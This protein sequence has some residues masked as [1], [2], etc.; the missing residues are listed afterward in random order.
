MKGTKHAATYERGTFFGSIRGNIISFVMWCSVL[1]IAVPA[2]M[3]SVVMRNTLVENGCNTLMKEA[4]YNSRLIDDWLI[5][6]ADIVNTMKG[7]LQTMHTD[8]MEAVMDLLEDN[9][10]ENPDALM[11]Y[12]C[13]A[14]DG[15][16][17]PANHS[18]LDLDPTT[19]GWWKDAVE[20]GELIYTEPYTD[21]ATGQMVISIA[22]PF[23]MDGEQA[24]ILADIT[25]DSLIAMVK[26]AGT[27][28]SMQMFL[29]AAD[30]SVITHENKE[31]L[32]KEEGN[33]IL[34]DVLQ[35]DTQRTD[36]ST[37]RDYD[38]VKKYYAIR[39]IG[40]TGWRL[41]VTQP[42]SEII[43]QVKKILMLPIIIDLVLL[44]A[45]IVTL[46]LVVNSL[47]KPMDTMK[48][49]IREKVIGEENCKAEKKEVKEISYLI[50]EL[51]TRFISTIRK[52]QSEAE[53][54]RDMIGETETHVASMNEN[55]MEI[56]AIMQET[57]ANVTTQ[58]E[59]ISGIDE[60]CQ[61]VAKAMDELT[62]S[63]QTITERANEIIERVESVVPEMLEDKNNAIHITM[64]SKQSLENAIEGTKV[65]GE[66]VKVSQAISAIAGQTNLLALNASIE[67]ARAGEAGKGFA[68]VADEIKQLSNTT[69]SEIDKVNELVDKVTDSVQKLSDASNKILTFLDEVVLKDYDSLETLANNYKDDAAYYVEVSNTLG[70][71]TE[72]LNASIININQIL[73]MIDVSQKEL[74]GAVQSVNENL[75]NITY[76]SENVS[77]ETKD[78]MGSIISLQETVE[79]FHM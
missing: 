41:G 73:N 27:D 54:I 53:R 24:V 60:N 67:A 12:C 47:L 1:I 55:I 7:S 38:G 39:E 18:S 20:S 23:Q 11:Y 45:F 75:Q 34:S 21:F 36:V 10:A 68:V 29:L 2:I 13:L 35:F 52:T 70:A 48:S 16:V 31:F 66:I 79:Q 64:D 61:D 3:N 46:N 26:D 59:N 51:E 50:E 74:D 8:D 5:R 63:T 69:S 28:E 22:A 6:Q 42:K 49:F 30:N 56:S 72:E 9:L 78:V 43:Q 19:R 76:A 25:I 57:G 40:T 33:T 32:P 58:T 37:F 14:Y 4:E 44:V 77:S 65:I 62:K 71:H 17:F 15:G